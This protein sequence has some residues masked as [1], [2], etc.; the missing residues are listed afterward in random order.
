[1]FED[2]PTEESLNQSK[3]KKLT[4]KELQDR[5]AQLEVQLELARPEHVKRMQESHKQAQLRIRDLG[6]FLREKDYI[7]GRLERRV[8]AFEQGLP[9]QSDKMKDMEDQLWLARKELAGALRAV[10]HYE[11]FPSDQ[12]PIV[13]EEQS[14]LCHCGCGREVPVQK[15]GRPGEY[16]SASCRKRAQRSRK[17]AMQLELLPDVTK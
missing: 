17:Q 3:V 4:M 7:I 9:P 1:M 12:Q 5:V 6:Y 8:K 14:H 16:Y 10:A 13:N 15:T 2:D 11:M